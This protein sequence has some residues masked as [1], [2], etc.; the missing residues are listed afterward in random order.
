MKCYR[1]VGVTR[2]RHINPTPERTLLQGIVNRID[3]NALVIGG[4]ILT[5]ISSIL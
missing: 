5:L 3:R 4:I 2:I 1:L